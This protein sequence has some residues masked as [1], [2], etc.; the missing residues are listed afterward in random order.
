[1]PRTSI[2]TPRGSAPKRSHLFLLTITL[3]ALASLI[4]PA[5]AQSIP[6]I[7]AKIYDSTSGHNWETNNG[8]SK[9]S[10]S[11]HYCEWTGI[12]CYDVDRYNELHHQI[13]TI[14]LSDNK[15]E[16]DLPSDIWKIPFL[17]NLILRANP[18]LN[19]GFRGMRHATQLNKLALSNTNIG[20]FEHMHGGELRELHLTGCSLN[21]PFP[22]EITEL[23]KLE[24]PLVM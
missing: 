12:T 18:D 21:M 19:V 22:I 2:T 9:S 24:A 1:M 14:D 17:S 7:L 5:S 6:E 23:K 15:L 8:W 4:Q 10:S 13:E 16:G 20:S 3:L 11:T